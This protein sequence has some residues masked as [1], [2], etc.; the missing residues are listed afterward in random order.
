MRFWAR[1]LFTR[2]YPANMGGCGFWNIKFLSILSLLVFLYMWN[3]SSFS[4]LINSDCHSMLEFI[5][6]LVARQ[7]LTELFR[8]WRGCIQFTL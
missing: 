1:K 6:D 7:I 8:P 5:S 2:G 3:A 4:E